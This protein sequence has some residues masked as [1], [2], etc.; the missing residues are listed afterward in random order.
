MRLK[1]TA[2]WGG[3]TTLGTSFTFNNLSSSS[4]YEYRVRAFCNGVPLVTSTP[5]GLFSSVAEFTTAS[6]PA[7]GICV[8]P[9]NIGATPT[10][11]SVTVTWDSAANGMNY[12]INIKQA[13]AASW[14]GTTVNTLSR[15]FTSLSPATNYQ[16]RIRTVCTP[17]T[18]TTANSL[19]SDTILFTTT[20]LANKAIFDNAGAA[21]WQVYPNPTRDNLHV[22]FNSN[23]TE[24]VKVDVRDMTGRLVQT[25]NYEPMIGQNT[26]D[27]NL[28]TAADG[29]YL[30]QIYQGSTLQFMNKV[31]KAH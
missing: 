5:T 26:L 15:T 25:L 9:T 24:T 22:D 12:F 17:G 18:T 21:T 11:N 10:S 31:Q 29:L 2:T 23:S 8:P 6:A 27:I 28:H 30:I 14:G 7:L 16:V 3:T 19:F 1:N 13:N 4:I 20:S